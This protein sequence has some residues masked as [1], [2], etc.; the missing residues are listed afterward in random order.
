MSE[1]YTAS[2]DHNTIFDLEITDREKADPVIKEMIHFW[3]GDEA[4]LE[5]ADGDYTKA[6]INQVMEFVFLNQRLPGKDD[7]GYV[8]LDGSFGIK[9]TRRG[10]IEFDS[11][12][13]DI[14]TRLTP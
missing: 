8:P 12:M 2:Y 14:Q 9:V 3:S 13:V 11:F 7:E 5:D 10:S 6:F 1:I 4:R